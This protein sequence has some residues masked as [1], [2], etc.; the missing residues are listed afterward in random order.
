MAL[1]AGCVL[2]FAGRKPAAEDKQFEGDFIAQLHQRGYH[3]L[4]GVE[5]RAVLHNPQCSI[6]GVQRPV[7]GFAG[8]KSER[9]H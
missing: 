2:L 9:S 1:P 4:Q 6:S 7:W 8:R 5:E 3:A